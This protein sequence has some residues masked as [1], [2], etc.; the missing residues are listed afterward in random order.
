MEQ[1]SQLEEQQSQLELLI[2]QGREQGY[3]TISE[4]HDHLP[5]E[6]VDADQIEDIIQMINDMGIKVLETA[7]DADD[8]MLAGNIADEDVVEEATKVLSTVE[9]ELGR[10]T[11]P[12]RMYMREMGTVELLTREGEINIAKRIEEGINEVQCAIAEYP[13]ALSELIAR[14]DQVEE[15][16]VRLSDLVTAFVDPNAVESTSVDDLD[17]ESESD[18]VADIDDESEDED[19][20]SSGDGGDDNSIDPELAREKFTLLKE[21]HQKALQ[22]I[23][24][25]GRTSKRSRDQ[26]QAL[27]DIFREFRLVP[28]QFDLLVESMQKMM[29]QVRAEERQIQRYAVEY[30]GMKKADFVKAFQ[31]N[32]LSEA[33]IEKAINAKKGGVPKLANYVD[34]IRVNIA[35]LQRLEETTGLTITQIREI[36]GRIADGELKA[37][38]AKKEMVEANLRLVIS[39]AKKYTNRGLQF[40]DL[41]QEGNI[42][43][44]KAVDKF[45]YRRGYKF[46]TYATWWIRQAITRSIADQ[47]RTIRIPVHMIE[48]INKLNRISRQCLQEMGREATPEELAEKMGMPEDKIRKV[49]KIAKEPISME[50]PVGDDDDS[51]L[52]DFI[53]DSSLELPLDSATA[54]SLRI[55]TNAVLE[56]L[57]PREAKVLRMRFGIDMNTDHTLEE[58]GKQFDVTRERIRQ[59]EAKA[60]RKLRHPSRSETLRSFLDD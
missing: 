39:I 59:I 53:E 48:T 13:E 40:L 29:K 4:V 43:L 3:L 28:K 26:I 27:S 9:S 58:V 8:L 44:M 52:G 24:K 49:L 16:T 25:H 51:H 56:G 17:E 42:G 19:G 12:V 46:S 23:Q 11:D 47:A 21:Q 37:R 54:E 5:E 38:K 22:A 30:A 14:Y 31:G 2:A 35:N 32:E 7:P 55:A 33:W 20:E 15:G 45:E 50:T 41:I 6:L 1:Y 60:L 18:T 36:G 57:T 34:N 10:T